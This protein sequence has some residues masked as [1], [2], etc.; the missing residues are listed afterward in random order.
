MIGVTIP[1]RDKR[2]KFK[3]AMARKVKKKQTS[4]RPGRR[5]ANTSSPGPGE[6]ARI[7]L[8]L[9]A[10][11]HFAAVTIKDIG[12][13]AKVN[14]A[15]IYYY[16][17][18]KE[19][20]FRAAIESAIDEAF[21]LFANHCSSDEHANA[22]DA[23]ANWFDVHVSLHKQLRNV[24]KIS[25][26]CKGVI[27]VRE[28]NEPIQRFYRHETEILQR[29][30]REGIE[31]GIFRTVD[32]VAV[33]TMI[34][35]SL[36]GIMARSFFLKDFDMLRTVEEFKQALWLHLGYDRLQAK[37]LPAPRIAVSGRKLPR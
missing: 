34:S 24:V 7:A 4:S 10:E 20:L 16:Y 19:E 9:F 5:T 28:A 2:G 21:L 14:S 35:T 25:L 1:Y 23:I 6:L 11:R 18:D 15:M 36:D 3:V 33:A 13:A 26:D 17:K 30:I 8:D 27:G 12:R 32:P 29:I 22:A 31:Q 37:D